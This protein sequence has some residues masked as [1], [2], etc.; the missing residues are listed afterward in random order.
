MNLGKLGLGVSVIVL[1]PLVAVGIA[2]AC[3][4]GGLTTSTSGVVAD[5]Q[6]ILLSVREQTTEVVVQIGV[7]ASS[8]TG[9]I[10][11]NSYAI[12]IPVPAEPVL[13]P[14]PV[15]AEEFDRLD[16]ATAPQILQEGGG[17]SD[18]MSCG[19][20]SA[21]AAND[22][23]QVSS[24][25]R[26]TEPVNIGPVTAVVLDADSGDD[27]TAW[28]GAN[29]FSIPA[30]NQSIVDDYVG[31]G[32]WFIAVRR[33]DAGALSGP[34]SVG[35][36]YTLPGDHR[37][38]SLRFA[39]LGAAPHVAFTVFIAAPEPVAPSAPFAALTL[40]DLD[41]QLLLE[42]RYATA[43]REAVNHELGHAFVL[44]GTVT[45]RAVEPALGPAMRSLLMQDTTITRASAIIDSTTLDTDVMFN[46][47]RAEVPRTRV[48]SS[49]LMPAGALSV[50]SLGLLTLAGSLRKRLRQV[51]G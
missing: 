16:D 18:G 7:P 24:D 48:L 49:P 39:Q 25:V 51:R 50:T 28:L 26:V 38:L 36:H 17:D 45:R 19:C 15:S 29:G 5:A 14:E 40:N 37:M 8:S 47:P 30:E 41:R 27:L 10:D 3:G 22:S 9:S 32:N 43:I 42:D 1:V 6:R 11:S 21:V 46:V 2:E 31:E 33:N 34:S 35:I 44:E 13:D 12:L 20:G 4:G 23:A